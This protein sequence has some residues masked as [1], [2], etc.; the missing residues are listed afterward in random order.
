MNLYA[1]IFYMVAGLIIVAT[2]L[3]ITRRNPVHAVIYLVISFFGSAMLFYL[4]GAPFLAA[5]EVIIYAG[6]I[7][8]L[9]LFVIMMLRVDA[10]RP[11]GFSLRE[12]LPAVILGIVFLV[13]VVLIVAKD[14]GSHTI[15]QAA[16]ATPRELGRFLFRRYWLAVEIV[17]F[18]LLIALVA[19]I[20][21]GRGR[22]ERN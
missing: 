7:M 17:S 21:L 10:A 12:W 6:A 15:L 3:A 1:P 11:P 4:L 19:A 14:P 2:G 9:F 20:Q 16:V 18:L 8:V 22:G 13:L 5:L